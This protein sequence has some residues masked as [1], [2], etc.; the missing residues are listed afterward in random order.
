MFRSVQKAG[1]GMLRIQ[2]AKE[3]GTSWFIHN[4]RMIPAGWEAHKC[5]LYSLYKPLLSQELENIST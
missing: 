2:R 1:R 4:P 3:T 5:S